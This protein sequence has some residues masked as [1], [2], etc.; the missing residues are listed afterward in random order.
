MKRNVILKSLLSAFVAVAVMF[1]AS[2]LVAYF[3]SRDNIKKNLVSDAEF[4]AAIVAASG[5]DALKEFGYHGALR[6]TVIDYSGNVVYESDTAAPKENHANREE[7][8]SAFNGN[9]KIVERYSETLQSRMFYYAVGVGEGEDKVV[10]RL[11][12]FSGEIGSYIL[13]SLPFVGLA[14]LIA[15]ALSYLFAK[16]LSDEVT[17]QVRGIR[18]SLR[19]LNEDRYQAVP[20]TMDDKEIY[21]VVSEIDRL[22]EAAALRKKRLKEEEAKLDYVVSHLKEGVVALSASGEVLL[23]N[24]P[25][26]NMFGAD[27]SAATLGYLI[28]DPA[29]LEKLEK[30]VAE[31]TGESF[32]YTV[33]KKDYM[34]TVESRNADADDVRTVIFVSDVTKENSAA[35]ERMEFFQNASHELKTPLTTVGGLS[36]LLINREDLP[37]QARKFAERIHSEA[38]R[39]SVLVGEM[40][41]ISELENR[42]KTDDAAEVVS[43]KSLTEELYENYRAEADLNGISFSV[44]GDAE[45]P[46]NRRNLS[47]LVGNLVGNA[48]HYNKK[49]GS[50]AVS[51]A[52][53]ENFVTFQVSDTGIGI[54]KEDLPR[55]TE[56]FYRVDKSRSKETGGTGLGLSIV[57]HVAEC[58]GADLTIESELGRGTCVNVVFYRSKGGEKDEK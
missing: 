3:I 10:V 11:A 56:R 28:D 9:P 14:M 6:L 16:K 38:K 42:K 12:A 18:E 46:I 21:A 26:L 19:S 50:V 20:A 22:F 4:T 33:D 25:F 37:P 36:E 35:R 8:K 2:T 49:G 44:T 24:A 5:A 15:F 40:L 13:K 30:L 32:A 55:I 48:V 23:V 58:Y 17:G 27:A 1:A 29:L 51:I 7:I 53:N 47:E 57:K 54:S 43:L 45:L 31:G 34:F 52:D 41:S 39:M